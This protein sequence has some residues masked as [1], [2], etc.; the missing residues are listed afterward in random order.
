M[1]MIQIMTKSHF[2]AVRCFNKSCVFKGTDYSFDDLT[3]YKFINTFNC[4]VLIPDNSDPLFTMYILRC[5]KDL[6]KVLD[7]YSKNST[8]SRTVQ[9]EETTSAPIF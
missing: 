9:N 3:M 8:S 4:K 1:L 7:L 5:D 2:F 6:Q